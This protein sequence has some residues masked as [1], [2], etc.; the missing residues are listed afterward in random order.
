MSKIRRE[1]WIGLVK[2]IPVSD[3]PMILDGAPGAFSNVVALARDESEYRRLIAEAFGE[4]GLEVVAFEDVEPL[5]Q[6]LDRPVSDDAVHRAE[7]RELASRLSE[8]VP[9]LFDAIYIYESEDWG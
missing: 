8:D 2:I 9:V 4:S 1:A 6:R 5:A 3:H 7:F